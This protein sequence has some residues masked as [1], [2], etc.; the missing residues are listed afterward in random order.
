MLHDRR[1]VRVVVAGLLAVT[2][3][4]ISGRGIDTNSVPNQSSIRLSVRNEFGFPVIVH[5]IGSGTTWRL[6]TVMAA[7]VREFRVPNAVAAAGPVEFIV[8]GYGN[9]PVRSGPMLLSGG[10]VVDFNVMRPLYA[11]TAILRR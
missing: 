9:A 1:R 3:A 6:G 10:R 8:S 11:S 2:G 7:T 5:A 4:C